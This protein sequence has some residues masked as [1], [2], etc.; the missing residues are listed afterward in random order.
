MIRLG[1]VYLRRYGLKRF[2]QKFFEKVKTTI[3]LVGRDYVFNF[4]DYQRWIAANEPTAAELATQKKSAL[5]FSFRPKISLVV[6]LWRTSPN[7]F[8][9][10]VESVR[11][12]TYD[13]WELCLAAAEVG[14]IKER[15]ENYSRLDERIKVRYLPKNIGIAGNSNE[16]IGLATGDYVGLLDHDDTLAP[17]AL[18]EIVE[19][20]N[21]VKSD[22]I[23]S[24]ED[25]INLVGNVR[26]HPHF[27]PNWNPDLLRSYNYI[28]HF[29]VI[30]R[31]LLDKIG[32]FRAG[33][34][35]S[36]DHD[37]FFRATESSKQISHIPKVLYH[38]RQHPE[39]T[40]DS[41]TV[42]S[43]AMTST[44]KAVQEHL[45]RI[46]RSATVEAGPFFGATRVRYQIL[47]NP[48]VSI[49]I[50]NQDQVELLHHCLESIKQLTTYQNY[51]V[52]VVENNSQQQATFDLYKQ[53]QS[54]DK[55]K[56]LKWSKPFNYSAINNLAATAAKGE[57]L[58]FLN[59]DTAVIS[60]DWLDELIGQCQ[61]PEN[62]AVGAKLYYDDGSIQHA[63]VVIGLG[64]TAGHIGRLFKHDAHGY[65]GWFELVRDLSA[66]TGACLMVKASQFKNIGGFDESYSVSFNDVDLCLRLIAHS[67]LVVWTPAAELYHYESKTRGTDNTTKKRERLENE[68]QLFAS[69]HRTLLDSGDPNYSPNFSLRRSDFSV[70]I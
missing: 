46:G 6:P 4:N 13:N 9:Q 29:F 10:M 51:E 32:G 21:R 54:W 25:K 15:L 31:Q 26:L 58:L 8:T 20:L 2:S 60:P 63:G 33:F 61:W 23:Y 5:E 65:F 64:G 28:T 68:E 27:K 3:G 69:R 39:S 12:Q 35:G 43:T 66:V 7:F 49:I 48:L 62:G 52:I 16:A 56:L 14:A 22:I 18:F 11:R 34:E 67:Q 37:L 55:F 24:D 70:K 57:Y 45:R 17:F 36:Q 40:S 53:Y 44:A 38:W 59:N 1:W 47:G 19:E 42:K 50:P 41:T 30:K